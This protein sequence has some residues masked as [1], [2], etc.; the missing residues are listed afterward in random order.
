[1]DENSLSRAQKRRIQQ[2]RRD[3][4]AALQH[5]PTKRL[6]RIVFEMT[7]IYASSVPQPD[8]LLMQAG[9][10]NVGLELM[11]L[12]NDADPFAYVALCAQAVKERQE[13]LAEQ[14][15]TTRDNDDVA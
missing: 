15:A 2:R 10:R 8:S 5:E 14:Q 12:L 7:G 1:M 13:A 3:V 11:A 9:R 4:V 6:L